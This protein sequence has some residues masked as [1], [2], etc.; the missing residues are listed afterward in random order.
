MPMDYRKHIDEYLASQPAEALHCPFCGMGHTSIIEKD[1][2]P[3][4]PQDSESVWAVTCWECA[5]DG[6]WGHT[7]SEAI[8]RW[9]KRLFVRLGGKLVGFDSEALGMRIRALRLRRGWSQQKL[10]TKVGT[11]QGRISDWE[12]GK[13]TMTLATLERVCDA[14][15]Q[16]PEVLMGYCPLPEGTPDAESIG[17]VRGVAEESGTVGGVRGSEEPLRVDGSGEED[18]VQP[19][20]EEDGSRQLQS[21]VRGGASEA[22]PSGAGG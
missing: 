22:D 21:P 11:T 16:G 13:F 2:E 18:S 6:P 12:S 15:E 5:Y 20:G 10:G 4:N 1:M 8:S 19:G 14:L 3:L 7:R 17:R 9:N